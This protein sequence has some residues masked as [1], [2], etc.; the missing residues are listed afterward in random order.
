MK[1]PLGFEVSTGRAIEIPLR[2][3]AVIG[4]TQ[5]SGKTTTLQALIERSSL[6]ALAFVTKRG[7][8]SFTRGHIV[9]PFFQE[10]GESGEIMWQYV[11]ALLETAVG[12]KLKMQ[13]TCIMRVCDASGV[14]NMSW[15]APKTLQAVADNVETALGHVRNGFEQSMYLQ[16]REYFRIVMPQIERL[17]KSRKLELVPGLNIMY[18]DNLPDEMQALCIASCAKWNR[19][20]EKGTV[21]ILPEATKFTGVST[22]A[23]HALRLL[24]REGAVLHNFIWMDSQTLTGIDAEIRKSVGVW[25]LGVQGEAIEAERTIKQLPSEFRKIRPHDVQQ[26]RLG[27]FLVSWGEGTR[28]VYVQPSWMPPLEA[29]I[30]AMTG[31]APRPAPKQMK[32]SE[33]EMWREQAEQAEQQ[34]KELKA[35]FENF[36]QDQVSM[37]RQLEADIRIKEG[38]IADLQK[39]LENRSHDRPASVK[40]AHSLEDPQHAAQ[41]RVIGHS[42]ATFPPPIVDA[43]V[44]YE[45]A[46]FWWNDIWPLV[47][48]RFTDAA[49]KDPV[50]LNLL[51]A[52]PELNVSVTPRVMN[53]TDDTLKGKN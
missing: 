32:N 17:P 35:Q 6:R 18:L 21:T 51:T 42:V 7:E 22:P 8:Q 37:M 50:I 49:M 40:M 53:L 46:E 38:T 47:R 45:E 41:D 29:Q 33:D 52:R 48:E 44:I 28:H 25:I 43:A 12:E 39:M 13:R 15:D 30:V 20:K 14:K 26:L 27:H 31:S 4:R 11:A 10:P 23:L 19:A 34:L 5:Q 1:I 9:P 16:L 36:Q 24:I 2:H 3:T